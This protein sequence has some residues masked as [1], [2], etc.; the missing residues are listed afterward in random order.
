M[1]VYVWILIPMDFVF[2]AKC[3]NEVE[4]FKLSWF[5]SLAC[6]I[7][8]GAFL[9]NG[10]LSRLYVDIKWRETRAQKSRGF[11]FT[12]RCGWKRRRTTTITNKLKRAPLRLSLYVH[13][14]TENALNSQFNCNAK[15]IYIFFLNIQ[16]DVVLSQC[17]RRKRKII[18]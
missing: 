1:C 8:D 3:A 11:K 13:L 18:L 5:F 10:A 6:F 4:I 7:L 17:K 9:R 14:F 15:Q 2:I 12:Q 16:Y